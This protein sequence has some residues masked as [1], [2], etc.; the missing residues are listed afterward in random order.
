MPTA[1]REIL[2]FGFDAFNRGDFDAAVTY[3]DPDIVWLDPSEVP[4]AGVHH[5]PE[6]VK[7][8]W[9]SFAEQW[10][11]M[12]MDPLEFAESGDRT[13]V[14]V[15]FSG[16]GRES[17]APMEIEF[18]QLWTIRDACALRVDSFLSREA[19]EEALH[20]QVPTRGGS[21]E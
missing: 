2:D 14:R 10:T 8:L 16:K 6:Q 3:F 17:G 19:A 12:R 18:F 1:E 5:G 15:H 11:D 9:R 21:G 20:A 13:L 4:D 7:A